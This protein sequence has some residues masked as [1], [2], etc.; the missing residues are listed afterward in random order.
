M[1]KR[2]K[3]ISKRWRASAYGVAFLIL[4]LAGCESM[5]DIDHSVNMHSQ[6][7]TV[8]D[9]L[10]SSSGTLSHDIKVLSSSNGAAKVIND[11]GVI[12]GFLNI[13]GV[14]KAELWSVDEN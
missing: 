13:N 7:Q 1:E 3:R 12:A 9:G 14:W 4:M 8:Q 10:M 6:N 5:T 2:K 11:H